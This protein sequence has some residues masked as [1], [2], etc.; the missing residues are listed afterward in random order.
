M[1]APEVRKLKPPK[2][3]ELI[4]WMKNQLGSDPSAVRFLESL[5]SE[6]EYDLS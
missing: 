1:M 5:K 6:A 2:D 4:E 3:E